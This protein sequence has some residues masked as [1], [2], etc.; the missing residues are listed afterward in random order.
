MVDNLC[1]IDEESGNQAFYRVGA[2]GKY[3]SEPAMHGPATQMVFSNLGY[4]AHKAIQVHEY[5]RRQLV[6]RGVPDSEI[7]YMGNYKKSQQKARLFADMNDGKVRVLIGSTENM[8][9]GVNAQQRLLALHNLDPLWYPAAHEQRVGRIVRQGNMNPEVRVINYSTEGTYDAQMWNLMASKGGFV[10]QFQQ[11][12]PSLREIEDI[13]PPSQYEQAMAMTINDPRVFERAQLRVDVEKLRR[14]RNNHERT[15]LRME[16]EIDAAKRSIQYQR[17]E[18]RGLNQDIRNRIETKGD[19]FTMQLGGAAYTDRADAAKRLQL[20]VAAATT[21]EIGPPA[22]TIGSVGGFNVQIRSTRHLNER[23]RYVP[24]LL[25]ELADNRT[26]RWHYPESVPDTGNLSGT[27]MLQSLERFIATGMEDARTRAEE[28]IDRHNASVE[29]LQ[30]RQREAWPHEERLKELQGRL[31][32]LDKDLEDAAKAREEAKQARAA[33]AP[34]TSEETGAPDL[35]NDPEAIL[36]KRPGGGSVW[37]STV[38]EARRPGLTVRQVNEAVQRI[39]KDWAA[40]P[41]TVI[42]DSLND[43]PPELRD[44][45]TL[46]DG[47]TADGL[48]DAG[49]GTVYLVAGNLYDAAHVER[50]YAH[51]AIGHYAM[52]ELLGEQHGRVLYDVLKLAERDAAVGAIRD[53]VRAEYGDISAD[54]LA[55]ETLAHM[56]EQGIRRPPLM[57]AAAALRRFLRRLGFDMPFTRADVEA[58]LSRAAR[59]VRE[60][61]PRVGDVPASDW[62]VQAHQEAFLAEGT[63]SVF[64]RQ[65]AEGERPGNGLRQPI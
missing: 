56:A 22:K 9:T 4:A 42:V 50:V 14:E 27:G 10:E 55:E 21:Q 38:R 17:E 36:P 54:Q 52:R 15:A 59:L 18:I 26:K 39:V 33:P 53:K 65:R 62:Q 41:N 2:D 60:G 19:K 30:A 7:A 43:L 5:V 63:Q 34:D 35:G 6:A 47:F 49:T 58:M 20:M 3:E 31:S 57:R 28:E 51:E 11:G 44:E 25:L 48:F 23:D 1:R 12:D 13:M 8:G 46:E 29:R 32:S 37:T 16:G 45:L 61:A 24:H 40:P 64:L